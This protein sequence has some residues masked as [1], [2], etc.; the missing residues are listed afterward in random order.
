MPSYSAGTVEAELVLDRTKFTQSLA[1][2]RAQARNLEGKEIEARLGL[3]KKTF[4]AKAALA[5]EKLRDLDRTKVE[6]KVDV[7]RGGLAIRRISLLKV[8]LV[9][10]APAGIPIF[11]G[12]TAATLG[13]SGAFAAAGAGAAVFGL[14]VG[15]NVAKAA[16]LSKEITKLEDQLEETD[17]IAKRA[18]IYGKL[19]KVWG[20]MDGTT[21]KFVTTLR[22]A[23]STWAQFLDATRPETL[24]LAGRALALFAP[25]LAPLPGVVSKFAPVFQ[26]WLS[27]INGFVTGTGYSGFINFISTEGPPALENLGRLVGNLTSGVGSLVKTFT[28]F[29][30]DFLFSLTKGSET[31]RKWA[32]E[33]G[34]TNGFRSF[35]DY[36]A[37]TGP[38]VIDMISAVSSS[39]VSVVTAIAPLGGPTLGLITGLATGLGAIA[40]VAPGLLQFAL[41]AG[42]V[43]RGIGA[44][45]DAQV[46]I[47]KR[48]DRFKA[49]FAGAVGPVA[50]LKAGLG[51]AMGLIGGPWGVAL[52]AGT[53]AL[54]YFASKHAEATERSR[55]LA[56]ALRE[57]QGAL[58]GATRSTITANL[59][60]T[61][62]LKSADKLGISL[63]QVTD[64]AINQGGELDVMKARLKDI[65]A[66]HST[67]VNT[68]K[69]V[70]T[71]WDAQGQ[72]AKSLLSS[73][74]DEN[75]EL[76]KLVEGLG[77]EQKASGDAIT[78]TDGLK[79]ATNE[80]RAAYEKLRASI[81]K[82]TAALQ[83]DIDKM[84]EAR[85]QALGFQNAQIGLEQAF[86]DAAQSVKDNGKT[87]DINTQ[88]GRDNKSALLGIASA[89]NEVVE[90]EKFKA[91]GAPAQLKILADQRQQFIDTAVA[92]G[93]SKEAA[94][95]MADEL[96]KTPKEVEA[97]V[98]IKTDQAALAAA[99]AKIKEL[100]GKTATTTAKFV[101]DDAGI[102]AYQAA[103]GTVPPVYPTDA[104]FNPDT[105]SV[106]EYV[107]KDLRRVPQVKQT[108]GKFTGDTGAV[109]SWDN[110]LGGIL[111][112]TYS[113]GHFDGDTGAIYAF[114][115]QLNSIPRR[116]TTY[117]GVSIS[118]ANQRLL[119]N[120]AASGGVVGGDGMV[121]H[122]FAGGGVV[123]GYAPGV[124]SR[125]A[126][127]SP[128]EGI[129]RPEVVR[130]LGVKTIHAL[131]RAAKTIGSTSST[132]TVNPPN[133]GAGRAFHVENLNI[134]NPVGQTSHDSMR[135]SAQEL[136]LLFGG[137]T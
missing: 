42:T 106:F 122:S 115:S 6:P 127:V 104:K 112:N 52:A 15:G 49:V 1:A 69:G 35:M 121:Q 63:D 2:A 118:G 110:T 128:G 117:V 56:A 3:D 90:S 44:L 41:I 36:I 134:V 17:D 109:N 59:E 7:D 66:A 37:Q 88:K 100:D 62:A 93:A 91:Q 103:L 125:M 84:K 67:T 77:R 113:Y 18:A 29:G 102:A 9:G 89:M 51:G 68:G 82:K 43:A 129:L 133:G 71:T 11:A 92:M 30:Q 72:A 33:L 20:G 26:S 39:I 114:R 27:G 70:I 55:N 83:A 53:I 46:A 14:A 81:E 22:G 60:Q 50:K 137:L 4:D 45:G 116:I 98:K 86:D 23:K 99:Q 123:P 61:G 111:K 108:D 105:Q 31:F 119:N 74:T 124:D 130:A 47:G 5:K 131:N 95:S 25:A 8:A 132:V 24:G 58:T 76:G 80:A 13:L 85:N 19:D 96:L 73:L 94:K 97:E 48:T 79:F 65:I 87:L 107:D 16:E 28:P 78:S 54:G 135:D 126:M 75:T 64:A 38:Q 57:E 40:D 21:K 10:L 34:S 32:S 12:L 101:T 136:S 120:A